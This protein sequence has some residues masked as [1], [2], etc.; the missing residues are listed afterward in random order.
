M[1]LSILLLKAISNG[2]DQSNEVKLL[3]R[4]LAELKKVKAEEQGKHFVNTKA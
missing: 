2:I 4:E 3:R 1:L